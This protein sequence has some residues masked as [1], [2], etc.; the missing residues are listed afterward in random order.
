LKQFG[1]FGPENG[2][3]VFHGN[4]LVVVGYPSVVGSGHL[5]FKVKQAGSGPGPGVDVIGFNMHEHLPTVRTNSRGD[6]RIEMVFT[7]DENNWNNRRSLQLKLKDVRRQNGQVD[8][9]K[10]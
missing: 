6:D 2:R 5:K 10:A 7:I 1:P 3:P 4:D 8:R 9:S